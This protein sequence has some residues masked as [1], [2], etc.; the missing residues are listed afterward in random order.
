MLRNVQLAVAVCIFMMMRLVMVRFV[1]IWFVMINLRV[2]SVTD[3]LDNRVE[4]VVLIS[5]VLNDAFRAIGFIQSVFSF[6]DIAVASFPLAFVVAG[7]RIFY[8]ILEFVFRMGMI[9][10]V[11]IRGIT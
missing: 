3:F 10:L 1:M 4:S 11:I 8:S 5:G 9:I 2:V 6:N 7:V